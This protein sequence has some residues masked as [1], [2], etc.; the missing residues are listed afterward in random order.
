MSR[1]A[2]SVGST[3]SCALNLD[4]ELLDAVISSTLVGLQMTNIQPVPVG[5]SRF[6]S[7]RHPITVM[8]GLV[9]KHSGNMTLNLS[10]AA[11]LHLTS[12]LMGEQYTQVT[13]ASIDAIMEIGNMVAG[14]IK[15]PLSGTG[16]E[17]SHI[18]LPSLVLGNSYDMI[19]ARG[20]ASVAVDFEVPDMPLSTMKGR[21]FSSAVSLLKAAGNTG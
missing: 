6:A 10:E 12:A 13:E 4:P 14:S 5:A 16:F 7:A 3:A 18:S 15:G 2:L 1:S 9:G 20:I 19:Y 11:M 21:F 8:V 17:I